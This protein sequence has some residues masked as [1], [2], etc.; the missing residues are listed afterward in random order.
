MT[1]TLFSVLYSFNLSMC[2]N[3]RISQISQF[4][5]FFCMPLIAS[6]RISCISLF[7]AFFTLLISCFF[8][9]ARKILAKKQKCEKRKKSWKIMKNCEKSENFFDFSLFN[10][11]NRKNF[12]HFLLFSYIS[13]ISELSHIT[14]FCI[15]S[16]AMQF[17]GKKFR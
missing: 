17:Y 4:S 13:L 6:N 3:Y 12:S 8:H 16:I 14:F 2:N 9:I 7:L 10:A 11:R 5:G 1:V 15:K